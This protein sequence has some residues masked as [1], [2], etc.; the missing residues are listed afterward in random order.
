MFHHFCEFNVLFSPLSCP[1]GFDS[2]LKVLIQFSRSSENRYLLPA[3]SFWINLNWFIF[4][5][6]NL[7]NIHFFIFPWVS[8]ELFQ[9]LNNHHH[10]RQWKIMNNRRNSNELTFNA[11]I[12]LQLEIWNSHNIVVLELHFWTNNIATEKLK[13]LDFD[14]LIWQKKFLLRDS[15]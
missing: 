2:D 15:A 8:T 7:T 12:V 6:N 14:L 1:F 11:S 9:E 13:N 10:Y 5:W 3:K 4:H